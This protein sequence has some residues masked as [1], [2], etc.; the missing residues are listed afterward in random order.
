[1]NNIAPLP[2]ADKWTGFMADLCG[3]TLDAAMKTALLLSVRD[4]DI[5]GDMLAAT[6]GYMLSKAL[7][8]KIEGIDVC[9]TGGDTSKTAV[10]TFN[11]STGVAFVMAAAGVSVVKHGNR[12]VSSLSGSSDVLASLKVPLCTTAEDALAQHKAHNLCF[13]SAPAFH[14]SLAVLAPI[15]RALGRPSF[16]NLLG[17]LCNPARTSKQLMGVYSARFLPAMAEAVKALGRTDAMVVHSEDG[18]D[19]ISLA[20]PTDA[21]VLKNGAITAE[22]ITIEDAGLKAAPLEKLAG[23]SSDQNAAIIHAIFSGTQGAGFDCLCINAAAGFLVA[24]RSA[25]L[26][27]GAWLAAETIKSG[28]ALQKLKNMKQVA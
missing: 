15:R 12:G 21:Y 13:V 19:E 6:A 5:T 3:D 22:R 9:G 11:I 8:L 14:P 2:A 24:G 18:L 10:K 27:E 17:P 1:M 23:G 26:K 16:L 4:E 25:N 7:P 28:L 20:A